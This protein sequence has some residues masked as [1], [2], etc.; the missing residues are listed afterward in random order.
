[1]Q[2]KKKIIITDMTKATEVAP[3]RPGPLIYCGP[4]LHGIIKTNSILK[5][6]LSA[7]LEAQIACC[8]EIN[9][10][11]VHPHRL[12]ETRAKVGTAG[13]AENMFYL[14]ILEHRKERR[15]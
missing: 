15:F 12:Q 2:A 1:M 4:D 5:G 3:A 7:L 13:T 8:P 6:Q 10:L 11:L 14:R 9:K